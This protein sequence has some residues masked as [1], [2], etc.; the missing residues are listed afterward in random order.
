MKERKRKKGRYTT[1]ERN[2]ALISAWIAA[3]RLSGFP[4]LQPP[5]L[6]R[7]NP[8]PLAPP[9]PLQSVTHIRRKALANRSL[10]YPT[11]EWYTTVPVLPLGRSSGY[12]R[13]YMVS[14]RRPRTK[15]S[16]S[17]GVWLPEKPGLSGEPAFW[18]RPF[19][20]SMERYRFLSTI[21][22]RV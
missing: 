14:A 3:Q 22:F 16:S 8:N 9:C 7:H 19:F 18:T 2:L 11:T 20:P 1:G 13:Y 10:C 12:C 21:S 5:P 6:P 17:M 15:V 4:M